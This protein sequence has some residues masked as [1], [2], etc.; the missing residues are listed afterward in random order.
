[1]TEVA[2][3]RAGVASLLHQIERV[4]KYKLGDHDAALGKAKDAVRTLVKDHASYAL[5]DTGLGGMGWD[6]LYDKVRKARNDIMHT[7][8][9]AVLADTRTKALAAVLLDALFGAAQEDG[10][11]TLTHVMVEH[12]VCAHR[13]QTI[14][15]V[16]RTMLVSDFSVLPLADGAWG[17]KAWLVLTADD[18]AS[19]L[20]D[21]DQRNDRMGKTVKEA[22]GCG[23][24]LRRARTERECTL[25][26]RSGALTRRD[27]CPCW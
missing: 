4:A 6:T 1:M 21:A 2:S 5:T 13:W 10:V 24:R 23:L 7:G 11:T 25:V 9:E 22:E 8:T 20:E 12:P 3:G 26:R 17:Q 27:H 15:D 14:A 19:W 18:L 16:R